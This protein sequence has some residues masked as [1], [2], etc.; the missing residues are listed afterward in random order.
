MARKSHTDAISPPTTPSRKL[1]RAKPST[2]AGVTPSKSHA[3]EEA[4]KAEVPVNGVTEPGSAVRSTK[5]QRAVISYNEDDAASANGEDDTKSPSKK[6]KKSPR[7]PSAPRTGTTKVE[8]AEAEIDGDEDEVVTPPKKTTKSPKTKSAKA[9]SHEGTE[10]TTQDPSTTTADA[11]VTTTTTTT[12]TTTPKPKR[13]TKAEK[14]AEMLPLATRTSHTLT[15]GAHVSAAGGVHQTIPNALHIGA[16]AFACFLK[17]QRK[18]ENPPLKDEH[19]TSFLASCSEHGYERAKAIVPHGSYLVNLANPDQEKVETAYASF[20]DDLKRCERLGIGLYN[21]HPGNTNG[22]PRA[23]ALG[24]LAGMLNRAHRETGNVVT[25]LENMAASA[26]ANT[27]GGTF[28]DLAAVIA[29]VEDKSRVGV[30]LDTCHAFAAGYDIRSPEAY[31]ATMAEFDKTVGAEYLKAVHVNDSKGV[32]GSNRDLHQNIGLGFI[33]LRGFWNVMND[34]RFRGVPMVLETPIDVPAS[35]ENIKAVEGD[36]GKGKGKKPPK[37]GKT[38]ED[39][40]IWAREI[41]LLE[42]LVG[43]DLEGEE[44]KRSEVEL[45]AKGEGERKKLQEQFDK[46][47]KEGGKKKKANGKQETSDEESD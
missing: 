34:E 25:L 31:A 26:E 14:E 30:C 18:W 5:R 3:I 24:R 2:S 20:L 29:R 10:V 32:L 11:T 44:F 16:N 36:G 38:V 1:A 13:K 42:S 23:E 27:I 33:G 40:G 41:K 28:K 17:S 9:K 45:A 8:D 4:V 21:F 19:A 46:K 22:T 15:I 6:S 7:R 43:M 39:K 12:T 47:V 35:A 37:L